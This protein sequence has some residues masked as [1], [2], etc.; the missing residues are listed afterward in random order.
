[1]NVEG[2]GKDGIERLNGQQLMALIEGISGL[3]QEDGNGITW[4]GQK[5]TKAYEMMS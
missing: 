2:S 3:V 1:M 4:L 5:I